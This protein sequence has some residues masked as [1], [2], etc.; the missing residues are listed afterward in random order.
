M[1]QRERKIFSINLQE[2]FTFFS[3]EYV[4][5]KIHKKEYCFESGEQ[6]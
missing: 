6:G 3:K 4:L 2:S 5:S 1:Q